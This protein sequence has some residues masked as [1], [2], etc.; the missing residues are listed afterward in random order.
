M[1]GLAKQRDS[2]LKAIRLGT[3]SLHDVDRNV[4]RV[5]E[6][7]LRSPHYAKYTFSNTPDLK[8]SAAV[9]RIGRRGHGTAQKRRHG[10]SPTRTGSQSGSF[11]RHLIRLYTGRN[12]Q[13][14][15]EQRLHRFA[16]TGA[17]RSGIKPDKKLQL[18]YE[19]HIAAEKATRPAPKRWWAKQLRPQ[20]SQ[21]EVSDAEIARLARTQDAAVI[22]IGRISGELL[23]RIAS[24]G[25]QSFR[26]RNTG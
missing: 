15:R 10:A 9:A 2:I 23:D 7:I 20:V 25:L 24:T 26:R 14:H 1:P 19:S 17:R 4:Q 13:R 11:R 16:R 6:L 5:L 21:M 22:T 12:R 18:A 8:A 3:L